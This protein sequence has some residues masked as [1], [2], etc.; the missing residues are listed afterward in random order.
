[1]NETAETAS[2]EM[3]RYPQVPAWSSVVEGDKRGSLVECGATRKATQ[4]GGDG[5]R[6][7][8]DGVGRSPKCVLGRC[9]VGRRAW[10]VARLRM[11]GRADVA[12]GQ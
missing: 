12:G 4:S 10:V 2:W 9:R 7:A 5:C 1:M 3:G 6:V 11:R 8:G